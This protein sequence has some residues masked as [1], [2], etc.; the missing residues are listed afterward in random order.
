[1]MDYFFPGMFIFFA[2]F[3]VTLSK[4]ESNYKKLVANNGEVFANRINK[5]LKVGGYLLF[6]C[7]IIW[8]GLVFFN[9]K[10]LTTSNFN[11]VIFSMIRTHLSQIKS[12]PPSFMTPTIFYNANNYKNESANKKFIDG[13]I[14]I[15][16]LCVL[17]MPR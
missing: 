12:A 9:K 7:A 2:I 4:S 16:C 11:F 8:F 3:S 10:Y 1:M 13:F 15:I 17:N 5:I 6:I 14:Q